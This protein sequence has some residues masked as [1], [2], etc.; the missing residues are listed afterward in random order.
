MPTYEY[1]CQDC[2]HVF[3]V[4]ATIREKVAGVQPVCPKC[5]SAQVRQAFA[6]TFMR[7]DGGGVAPVSSGGCCSGGSCA[8][9]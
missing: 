2:G 1:R 3:E 4:F 5:R 7:R 8:C 9:G 6:V